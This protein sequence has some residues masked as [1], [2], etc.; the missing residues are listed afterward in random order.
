MSQEPPYIPYGAPYGEQPPPGHGYG[1]PPPPR[2]GGPT[3][4]A[5]VAL[6][7]NLLSVVGC[8]NIFGVGGA[9]LA[10]L[11]LQRA[12]TQP[13]TAR[14]L[15]VGSWA[16]FGLGLLVMATLFVFLGVTGRLDD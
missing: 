5:I 8:C 15:L 7:L 16:I 13:Q 10:V 14:G 12:T 9:V 11:A 2:D 6:V 1:P 4:Q 3:A